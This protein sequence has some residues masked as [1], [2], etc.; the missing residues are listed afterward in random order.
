MA[1]IKQR[2]IETAVIL[3]VIWVVFFLDRF[4]PLERFGVLPRSFQGIFGIVAMPFLHADW[5]HIVNNS[6]PLVILLTVLANTTRQFWQVLIGI[7]FGSG[8]L[9]WLLGRTSL[10]IGASAVVFGLIGYL[11]VAGIKHREFKSLVGTVIVFSLYGGTILSGISPL[12]KHISWEGHLFGLLVGAFIAWISAN[13][14]R[15]NH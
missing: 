2:A 4:L 10:H 9:L 15:L 11:L 3:I 7:T 14:Q 13:N 1:M 5:Q 12:Q 6:V 8:L